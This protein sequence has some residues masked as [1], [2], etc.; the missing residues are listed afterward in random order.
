MERESKIFGVGL[1]KT[2]IISLTRALKILGYKACHFPKDMENVKFYFNKRPKDLLV[3]ILLMTKVGKFYAHSCQNPFPTHLS[4]R[5]MLPRLKIKMVTK[6]FFKKWILQA[7]TPIIGFIANKIQNWELAKNF[8]KRLGNYLIIKNNTSPSDIIVVLGGG[9]IERIRTGV[10]L[11]QKG[12]AHKLLIYRSISKDKLLKSNTASTSTTQEAIRLGVKTKDVIHEDNPR[13]TADEVKN[14]FQ[15]FTELGFK[16][17]IIVT[18]GYHT[19]RVDILFRGFIKQPS[20]RISFC[21]T[22][23]EYFDPNKWWHKKED[24]KNLIDEY[25]ALAETFLSLKFEYFQNLAI[26]V[27]ALSFL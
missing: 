8:L 21:S 18:D 24:T 11:Y 5:L 6:E 1:S 10:R 22:G 26:F 19:K 27:G 7:A 13:T 16:S 2:G 25:F 17:A 9:S 12:I 14:L 20:F 15:K 23:R 4:L 3:L